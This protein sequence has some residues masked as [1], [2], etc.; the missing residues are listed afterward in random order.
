MIYGPAEDSYLLSRYVSKYVK[1]KDFLDMGAG[2]GIQSQSA[3]K[4]GA[5]SILAADI[6][7]EVV[8]FLKKKGIEVVK[9]NLFEKIDGKFDLIAF[10]PPYLPEDK[11][12]DKESGKITSGGVKGDEIICKFLKNVEKF[13]KPSGKVLLIVSSLTPR[14]RIDEIL[15]D[16]KISKEI[17]EK[18]K[19]FMEELEIWL[20]D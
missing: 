8:E 17:L 3:K 6:D 7:S 13:L 11:R 15:E 16:K 4:A 20:L 10:N 12:E 9:S 14:E 19:F 1:N 5:N 2:S 18:E